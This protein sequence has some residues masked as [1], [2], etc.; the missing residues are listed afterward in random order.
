MDLRRSEGDEE[1]FTRAANVDFTP[2]KAQ[3]R[4][5]STGEAEHDADKLGLIRQ[6][7][8]NLRRLLTSPDRVTRMSRK[9]RV[10]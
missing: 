2:V 4:T 10:R 7:S 8:T 3:P 9:T 1:R 6:H 5:G